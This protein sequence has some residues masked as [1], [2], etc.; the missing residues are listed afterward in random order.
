MA[1]LAILVVPQLAKG[2]VARQ[3]T[4]LAVLEWPCIIDRFAGLPMR[5]SKMVNAP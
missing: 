4:M 2:G 3:M 1:T 5:A